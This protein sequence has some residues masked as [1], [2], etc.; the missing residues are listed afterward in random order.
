MLIQ[1]QLVEPSG[2]HHPRWHRGLAC[3]K[4]G[5][6]SQGGLV[7]RAIS[8]LIIRIVYA[9]AAVKYHVEKRANDL[10]EGGFTRLVVLDGHIIFFWVVHRKIPGRS[11][12]DL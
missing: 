8:R 10:D 6:P 11:T 7:C 9:A 3:D 4:I 1:R 12:N 5:S 2:E